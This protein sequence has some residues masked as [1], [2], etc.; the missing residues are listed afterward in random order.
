MIKK[1]YAYIYSHRK[2][3]NLVNSVTLPDRHSMWHYLVFYPILIQ[4]V[5]QLGL[6]T[7]THFRLW[8][9]FD[10][11][12]ILISDCG[13]PWI[14]SGTHMECYSPWTP[15]FIQTDIHLGLYPI[16][17]QTVIHRLSQGV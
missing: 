3:T 13:S 11:L 10:S 17:I 7:D 12:P 4:T 16:P 1:R 9:T 2:V 15:I 6:P 5:I 8:F 14:L